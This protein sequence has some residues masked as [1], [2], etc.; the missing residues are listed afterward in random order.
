MKL[1]SSIKSTEKNTRLVYRSDV[2]LDPPRINTDP[3]FKCCKTCAKN[4]FH[5]GAAEAA[6]CQC[7]CHEASA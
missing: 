3:R 7:T 1:L 4:H 6:A 5:V 2:K